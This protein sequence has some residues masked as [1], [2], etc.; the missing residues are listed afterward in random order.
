METLD[1]SRSLA[2]VVALEHAAA[3]NMQAK[4]STSSNR[5]KPQRDRMDA[6]ALSIDFVMAYLPPRTDLFGS[7]FAQQLVLGIRDATA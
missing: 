1:G 2:E 4:S 6:K 7:L 5:E 3:D